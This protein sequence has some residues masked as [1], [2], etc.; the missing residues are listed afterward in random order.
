[1][2]EINTR[3]LTESAISRHR[4]WLPKLFFNWHKK[5]AK[6]NL[7]DTNFREI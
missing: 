3:V 7:C 1:L 5:S 6:W 2:R 4:R